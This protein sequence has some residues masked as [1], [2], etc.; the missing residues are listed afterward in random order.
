MAFNSTRAEE[1]PRQGNMGIDAARIV[2]LFGGCKL[3]PRCDVLMLG[4]LFIM[5]SMNRNPSAIHTTCSEHGA[6]HSAALAHVVFSPQ[7]YWRDADLSESYTCS[8]EFEAVMIVAQVDSAR[9][10]L[11]SP[12]STTT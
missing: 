1:C 7:L 4:H 6:T 12:R 5:N 11:P 8:M 9:I 3:Q 2:I 10:L